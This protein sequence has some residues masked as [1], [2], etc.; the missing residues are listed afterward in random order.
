[1]LVRCFKVISLDIS[2]RVE[3]TYEVVVITGGEVVG[4]VVGVV[5][6]GLLVIDVRVKV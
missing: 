3:F 4:E 5:G 6:L 2:E 1:M